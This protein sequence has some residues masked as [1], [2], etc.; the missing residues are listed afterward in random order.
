[1]PIPSHNA[2]GAQTPAQVIWG[3]CCL[4]RQDTVRQANTGSRA[5]REA[6]GLMPRSQMHRG[7]QCSIPLTPQ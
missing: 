4:K 5:Q 3:A 7:L 2:F 6:A 1:M